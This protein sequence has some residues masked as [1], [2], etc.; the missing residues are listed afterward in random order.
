ML[1]SEEPS[2]RQ[3]SMVRH[4]AS[5]QSSMLVGLFPLLKK[6][7]LRVLDSALYESAGDHSFEAIEWY[8]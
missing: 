1:K 8:N 5:D 4:R 6:S 3:D 2:S 7:S